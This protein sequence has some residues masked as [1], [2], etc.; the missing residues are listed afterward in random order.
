M[1]K[2]YS[3]PGFPGRPPRYMPFSLHQKLLFGGFVH[4]FGWIFFGFGMIFVWVFGM[5]TDP[6]ARIAFFGELEK[7]PGRIYERTRTNASIGGNDHRKG[8]P[9]FRYRHAFTHQDQNYTG[10]SYSTSQLK[11][12]GTEVTIEF[13][14][15]QPERSRIIGMRTAIFPDFVL[16]VFLFPIVGLCLV[17]FGFRAGWKASHLLKIGECTTGILVNKE[18]TDTRINQQT[19]F[20][21]TFEFQTNLGQTQQVSAKTHEPHKLEDNKSELL[22]YDPAFPAK[23]TLLDHLPGA[24]EISQ[25]GQI[26][27]APSLFPGSLLILPT[28]SIIGHSITFCYFFLN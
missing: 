3:T 4:Q 19:V 24:I 25:D 14:P 5:N 20:K 18:A 22:F 15:G 17:F 1:N 9:I 11:S 6:L 12:N 7:V 10:E 16:F 8:R 2:P 28:L 13:P 21:L 26:L 27:T 23:A